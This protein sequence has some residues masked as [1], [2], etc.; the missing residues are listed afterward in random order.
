MRFSDLTELEYHRRDVLEDELRRRLPGTPIEV[1]RDVY[2]DHGQKP[3]FQ[4]QYGPLEID[5][6]CWHET[7]V[8]GRLLARCS[9]YEGFTAHVTLL[10]T[11]AREPAEEIW[12]WLTDDQKRADYWRMHQTWITPP[13][14]LRGSML[15]KQSAFHLVEGHTRMRVL[16]GAHAQ[17]V[18]SPDKQHTVWLGSG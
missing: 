5:R 11:S 10:E 1:I 9:Y 16:R 15:G 4:E 12:H 17:G 8:S 6:I 18:I 2:I 14:F 7:Q 13:F 3:E